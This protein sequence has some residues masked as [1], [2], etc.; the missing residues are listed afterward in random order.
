MEALYSNKKLLDKYRKP[1]PKTWQELLDTGKEILEKE[2][3]EGNTNLIG[4]NGLFHG[5]KYQKF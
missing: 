3:E 4:Y 1:V 5:K 2:R